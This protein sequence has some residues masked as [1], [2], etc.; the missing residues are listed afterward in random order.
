MK[1]EDPRIKQQLIQ[2]QSVEGNGLEKNHW[3]SV[4]KGCQIVES[5]ECQA[6]NLIFFC[7]QYENIKAL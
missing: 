3:M 1:V 6:V 5:P 2:R 7:H 4:E